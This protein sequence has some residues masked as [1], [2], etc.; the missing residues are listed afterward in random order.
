MFNVPPEAF[1]VEDGQAG[2][3]I[4]RGLE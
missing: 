2:K 3:D 1:F 4:A